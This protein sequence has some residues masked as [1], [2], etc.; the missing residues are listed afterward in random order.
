MLI[1]MRNT[2]VMDYLKMALKSYVLMILISCAS[3]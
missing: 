2:L 1:I 3:V